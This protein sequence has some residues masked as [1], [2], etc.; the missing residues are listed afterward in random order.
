MLAEDRTVHLTATAL[1][2]AGTAASGV[3]TGA[4]EVAWDPWRS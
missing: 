4:Q 2:V 3:T 1:V